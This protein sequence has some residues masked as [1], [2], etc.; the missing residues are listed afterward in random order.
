MSDVVYSAFSDSGPVAIKDAQPVPTILGGNEV[1]FDSGFDLSDPLKLPAEGGIYLAKI[2]PSWSGMVGDLSELE[3]LALAELVH[4][5]G[6]T[7]TSVVAHETNGLYLGEN[8]GDSPWTQAGKP[9]LGLAT[10]EGGGYFQL[11]A[12]QT[13]SD[14]D[15]SLISELV[16]V[17]L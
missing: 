11:Q 2:V 12:S 10:V 1:T 5:S 14:E 16:L 4:I 13:A 9:K 17:K 8:M 15:L 3:G 7:V 6:E